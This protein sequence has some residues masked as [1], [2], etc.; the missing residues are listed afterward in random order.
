MV[1]VR[2]HPD[3]DAQATHLPPLPGSRLET[4]RD[5]DAALNLLSPGQTV[6]VSG[7]G[8]PASLLYLLLCFPSLAFT[9]VEAVFSSL[10]AN[11]RGLDWVLGWF[12]EFWPR[13]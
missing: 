9:N 7:F 13:K 8:A 1:E 12:E 2:F 6:A 11:G 4:L 3:R 10:W 5:T